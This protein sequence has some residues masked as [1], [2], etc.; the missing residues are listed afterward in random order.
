MVHQT[1]PCSLL[2][3]ESPSHQTHPPPQTQ[4]WVEF[5]S[6]LRP[7]PPFPGELLMQPDSK[8]LTGKRS[9][10]LK[11]QYGGRCVRLVLTYVDTKMQN[12]SKKKW[13]TNRKYAYNT[14]HKCSLLFPR[15]PPFTAHR[16]RP[17]FSLSI[18]LSLCLLLHLI[19]STM[20][21]TICNN[22]RWFAA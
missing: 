19:R 18:F 22:Y 4:E 16:S 1:S 3:G 13:Q 12:I 17:P 15:G 5:P 9:L 8:G 11:A 2:P 21:H 10:E 6:L 14:L 20:Q 7:L